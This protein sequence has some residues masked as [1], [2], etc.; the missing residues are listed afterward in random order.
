M[1]LSDLDKPD[2]SDATAT[3][4]DSRFR[5]SFNCSDGLGLLVWL[6]QLAR[7]IMP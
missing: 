2:D 7:G 1:A 3:N 4:G 5:S 6:G